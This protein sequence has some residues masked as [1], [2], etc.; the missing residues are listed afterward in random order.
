MSFFIEADVAVDT[1]GDEEDESRI[2]ED[3]TSLSD[4]GVIEK[5]QSGGQ[6]TGWQRVPRFPHD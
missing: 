2:E 6:D 3:Q 5:D 1:E 4:M